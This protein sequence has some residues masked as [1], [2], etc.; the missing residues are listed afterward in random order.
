MTPFEQEPQ[1][2]QL[3]S[4]LLVAMRATGMGLKDLAAACDMTTTSIRFYLKRKRAPNSVATI[5]M[6]R[7]LGVTTD[8]ILGAPSGSVRRES[9]GQRPLAGGPR[10]ASKAERRQ[11]RDKD[12]EEGKAPME[13]HE[14]GT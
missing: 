1:L 4:R 14:G 10:E 13:A 11:V 8:Y 3:P 5:R 7:A 12:A 6:A 9:P 2:D